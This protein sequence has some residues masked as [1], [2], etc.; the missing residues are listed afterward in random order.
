MKVWM[1][2][3]EVIAFFDSQGLPRPLRYRW[4]AKDQPHHEPVIVK[5]DRILQQ[6]EEKPAGNRMLVYRCQSVMHDLERVY[7]LKYELSTCKWFL[8]KM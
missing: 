6:H 8:F 4:Q 3:I 1:H 7:E 2:P 5:V